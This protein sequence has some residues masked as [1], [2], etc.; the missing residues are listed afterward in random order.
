MGTGTKDVIASLP[1]FSAFV[2]VLDF[3]KMAAEEIEHAIVYQAKQYVP[4]PLSEVALDWLK[5]AEFEDE[6]GFF[7]QKI[8]L[9]S[10]PQEQIKK[11]QAIFLGGRPHASR[12]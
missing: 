3:P 2:S 10:V 12:P 4:L 8:L 5:V 7:H 6:K 9:I 11:Y 1:L